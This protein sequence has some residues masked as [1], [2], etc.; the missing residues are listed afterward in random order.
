[1]LVVEEEEEHKLVVEEEEEHILVVVGV[2]EHKLVVEGEH[3]LEVVGLSI[4]VEEQVQDMVEGMVE[5]LDMVEELEQAWVLLVIVGR[6]ASMVHQQLASNA[7]YP[8]VERNR[9]PLIS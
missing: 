9:H 2:E 7:S 4:L 8:L 3:K 1:M 5:E 6:V